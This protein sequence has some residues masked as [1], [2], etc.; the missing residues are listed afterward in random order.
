MNKLNITFAYAFPSAVI[1]QI[2]FKI[3]GTV[4]AGYKLA[5]GTGSADEDVPFF[6]RYVTINGFKN[7]ADA[8]L[9]ALLPHTIYQVAI[10][11]ALEISE[12]DITEVPNQTE[13]GLEVT[14][15]VKAWSKETLTPEIQ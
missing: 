10:D 15:S 11:Q 5:D 3:D 1:P 6:G 9:T 8:Q 7:N 2:I 4:L 12:G 13:V 14:I